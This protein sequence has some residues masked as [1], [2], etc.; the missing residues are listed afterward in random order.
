MLL[1]IDK[2]DIPR[3]IRDTHNY[4]KVHWWW[5]EASEAPPPEESSGSEHESGT[6]PYSE[7]KLIESLP[8]PAF[9]PEREGRK[10]EN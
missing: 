6:Q 1:Q 10:E 3:V 2:N 8:P 9:C 4:S 5:S 7:K